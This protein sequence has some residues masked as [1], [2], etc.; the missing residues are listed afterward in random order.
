[1]LSQL[2]SSP[3]G[4]LEYSLTDKEALLKQDLR[5]HRC[6]GPQRNMPA[7]TAHI[8]ACGAPLPGE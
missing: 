1:M 3:T 6:G 2:A 5:C 8:A 7:L 4:R